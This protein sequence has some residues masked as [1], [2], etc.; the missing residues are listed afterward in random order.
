MA[1]LPLTIYTERS[2]GTIAGDYRMWGAALT[3]V[4][5][6]MLINLLATLLSKVFA[7]KTK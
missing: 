2:T 3:L 5:V 1:S 6:I 7:V 4:I